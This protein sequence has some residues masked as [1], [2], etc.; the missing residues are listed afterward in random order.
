MPLVE[1][2]ETT[3]VV[4]DDGHIS[5]ERVK[6]SDNSDLSIAKIE[7]FNEVTLEQM[8]NAG[9]QIQQVSTKI[10]T[11]QRI[12]SLQEIGQSVAEEYISNAE[13]N[14]LIEKTDE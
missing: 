7:P 11:P 10:L 5:L 13:K 3:E 12:D 1:H 2:Y 9:V 4:H 8:I 6:V 14:N